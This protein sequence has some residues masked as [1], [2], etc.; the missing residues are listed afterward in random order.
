MMH[1]SKQVL[2]FDCTSKHHSCVTKLTDE[3]ILIANRDD[4]Q[5]C[6]L[7]VYTHFVKASIE[8]TIW[9][10]FYKNE[11]NDMCLLKKLP[12]DLMKYILI[13]LG[14][15]IMIKPYIKITI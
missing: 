7:N 10:G 1:K 6:L 4:K 3:C 11:K 12:T 14:K 15:Q 8:R 2:P 5:Y 9:I 13:L